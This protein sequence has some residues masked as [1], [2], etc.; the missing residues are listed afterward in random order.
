MIKDDS[1][2]TRWFSFGYCY[3]TSNT[4]TQLL[5]RACFP[6]NSPYLETPLKTCPYGV[7]SR[8]SR[9]LIKTNNYRKDIFFSHGFQ[10]FNP[11]SLGSI[12]GQKIRACICVAY[13]EASSSF[14]VGL[15]GEN[16]ATST[17]LAFVL[18]LWNSLRDH[19]RQGGTI[20]TQ[21]GF[22]YLS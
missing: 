5:L 8:Y 18:S 6:L 9:L 12:L 22:S 16:M 10:G 1:R 4:H 14:H 13:G 2:H 20:H 7:C 17:Q 3:F 21:V 15:G 19:N 11:W